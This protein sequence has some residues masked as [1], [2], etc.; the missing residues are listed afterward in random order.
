MQSYDLTN[1]QNSIWVTEEFFKGSAINNICGTAFIKQ[2]VNFDLLK[3]AIILVMENNDIFKIKFYL[4]QDTIMQYVSDNFNS[5]IIHLHAKNASDLEQM[6]KEIV[7]KSFNLFE[8]NP[9]NFYV[10]EFPNKHGAFMLNIL[11]LS[12]SGTAA[13]R[14][15]ILANLQK[16]QVTVS[17]KIPICK[18]LHLKFKDRQ[19]ASSR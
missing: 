4:E 15:S 2:K 19:M 3:K 8:S 9:Y 11:G 12:S 7:S 13:A 14:K 1:P 17:T 10:F 5:D 18:P 16:A 6:Q